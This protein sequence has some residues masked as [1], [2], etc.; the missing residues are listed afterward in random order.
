MSWLDLNLL[1]DRVV[2]QAGG[3]ALASSELSFEAEE[4]DVVDG[5][6]E[7]V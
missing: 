4:R 7:L 3:N 2:D 5:S 6:S 1:V